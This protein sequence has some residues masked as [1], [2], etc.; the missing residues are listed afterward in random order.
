MISR[1]IQTLGAALLS[2]ALFSAGA[3]AKNVTTLPFKGSFEDATFALENAI[4]NKGLVIDYVSHASE[5][6]SRTRADLGSDIK[7]FDGADIYL[8][9]SAALSRKMLEADALNIAQ[10]PYSIFVIDRKGKVEVGYRQYP[11]GVMQQVQ[12]LLDEIARDAV[13]Q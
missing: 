7:L 11:D 9:C 3:L 2:L 4:L 13:A 6:L 12:S 10:C 8:F 1:L 5:M